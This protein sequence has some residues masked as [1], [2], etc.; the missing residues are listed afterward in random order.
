MVHIS[1]GFGVIFHP[2]RVCLLVSVCVTSRI[3]EQPSVSQKDAALYVID[4]LLQAG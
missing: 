2:V 3:K 4:L 1:A